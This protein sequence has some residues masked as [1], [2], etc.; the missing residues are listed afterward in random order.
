M[1]EKLRRVPE[2]TS[3]LCLFSP[4]ITNAIV[5]PTNMIVKDRKRKRK[6]IMIWPCPINFNLEVQ[7]LM[8]EEKR[9]GWSRWQS[10]FVVFFKVERCLFSIAH[11][12]FFFLYQ[13]YVLYFCRF[14]FSL[15]YIHPST[16][17]SRSS[18]RLFFLSRS[19]VIESQ[20]PFFVRNYDS[21]F[22]CRPP[23]LF[24]STVGRFWRLK[25]TRKKETEWISCQ[26]ELVFFSSSRCWR[27]SSI[28]LY[29]S[30]CL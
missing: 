8:K 23:S 1:R 3:R 28:L 6:R 24:S 4:F 27:T 19:V 15:T 14:I 20:I 21:W 7:M 10:L 22:G 26:V 18:L 16:I 5:Y 13:H 29:F 2:P 25:K 12:F 17:E 9:I 11:V 30:S